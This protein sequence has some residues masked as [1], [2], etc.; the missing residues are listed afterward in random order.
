[1]E[2]TTAKLAKQVSSSKVTWSKEARSNSLDMT[3]AWMAR[4]KK[5]TQ[6]QPDA[7]AVEESKVKVKVKEKEGKK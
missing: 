6:Q 3:M 5:K 1:M 7:T 4:V 2:Q